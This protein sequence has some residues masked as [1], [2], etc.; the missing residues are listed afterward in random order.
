MP[1]KLGDVVLG[2]LSIVNPEWAERVAQ[3]M[4][5]KG[6]PKQIDLWDFQDGRW[7][8]PRGYAVRLSEHAAEAGVEIEWDDQRAEGH[9]FFGPAFRAL[10]PIVLRP[11]QGPAV[12]RLLER[13]QGILE[14]PPA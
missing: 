7:I 6:V 1:N 8:L 9:P 12:E 13:E 10:A 14:A 11:H 2:E 4:Y 3:G 5:V